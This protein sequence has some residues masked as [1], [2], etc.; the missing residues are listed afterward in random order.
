[1]IFRRDPDA[2]FAVPNLFEYRTCLIRLDMVSAEAEDVFYVGQIRDVAIAIARR[3]TAL[4]KA[5]GGMG[6]AGPRQL[7]EVFVLGRV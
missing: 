6:F 4:A 5:R 7:M 1:M 3:C 2:T